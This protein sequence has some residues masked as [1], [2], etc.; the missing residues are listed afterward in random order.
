MRW[1]PWEAEGLFLPEVVEVEVVEEPGWLDWVP[2]EETAEEEEE[3]ER[4]RRMKVGPESPGLQLRQRP[5][6]M[7]AAEV[8]LLSLCPA[9]EPQI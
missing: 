4:Q 1:R 7:M 5:G 8:L 3:L 6:V 2:Q 9:V